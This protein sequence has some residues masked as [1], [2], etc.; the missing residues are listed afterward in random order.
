MIED[1]MSK[2]SKRKGAIPR[3]DLQLS[4]YLQL[5]ILM[6]VVSIVTTMMWQWHF[7]SDLLPRMMPA[8]KAPHSEMDHPGT[9]S[10]TLSLKTALT[11]LRE[12][13]GCCFQKVNI[14]FLHRLR[15]LWGLLNSPVTFAASLSTVTI[16]CRFAIKISSI[17]WL[18]I[19]RILIRSITIHVSLIWLRLK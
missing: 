10:L 19:A 17:I 3:L 5:R 7:T 6:H 8:W 12:S 1:R 18:V 16:T 13:V 11:S 14:G 9:C 15:F 4:L 2:I